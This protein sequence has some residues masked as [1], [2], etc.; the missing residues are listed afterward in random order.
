MSPVSIPGHAFLHHFTE[1]G[2]QTHHFLDLGRTVNVVI[3][4]IKRPALVL[5]D[6][7]DGLAQFSPGQ[8]A[9]MR[10]PLV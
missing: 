4:I 10:H 1:G 9:V 5:I 2:C 6:L 3:E 7:A 8:R